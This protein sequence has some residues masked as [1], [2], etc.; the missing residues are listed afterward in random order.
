VE[1]WAS[2]AVEGP[3]DEVVLRRIA[4]HVGLRIGAVHGK[5]GKPHLRQ[6]ILGY[7]NAAR[8]APWV[9]LV[10]LDRE[11]ECA[12]PMRAQWIPHPAPLLCFRIAVRQ[13][14]SWL[15][16]DR[17]AI[18]KFLRVPA[19]RVPANPE[20][21]DNARDAMVALAVQSR[22]TAIRQDMVPRPGSGRTTGPAYGS[23]LIEFTSREWHPDVAAASCKS[24]HRCL[25]RL[26]ELRSHD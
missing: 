2:G 10:D 7:N 19:N 18:A 8:I 4:D 13:I 22:Q 23:R 5:N 11:A 20:A 24:L 14:E 12:P 16:A 9:I 6:Q 25:N 26:K 21:L 3:T 15:L 17:E 1:V